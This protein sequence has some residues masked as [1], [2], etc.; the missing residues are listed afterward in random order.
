MS[1][2]DDDQAG[3]RNARRT[4]YELGPWRRTSK[5]AVEDAGEAVKKASGGVTRSTKWGVRNGKVWPE[6][7]ATGLQA[8]WS[9]VAAESVGR[10][11]V[12][13]VSTPRVWPKEI[14]GMLHARSGLGKSRKDGVF[15]SQILLSITDPPWPQDKRDQ[16]WLGASR[17]FCRRWNAWG[18]KIPERAARGR[19]FRRRQGETVHLKSFWIHGGTLPDQANSFQFLT[20]VAFGRGGDR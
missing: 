13:G 3:P 2:H 20:A 7:S 15:F 10:G 18:V 1:D 6:W 9:L 19:L 12:S 16:G 8:D 11:D 4:P 14:R 17:K 5:T